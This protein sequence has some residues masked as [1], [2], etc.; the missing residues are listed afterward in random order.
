M[1]LA[2]PWYVYCVTVQGWPGR[3]GPEARKER[4]AM[5]ARQWVACLAA[6]LWAW[7]PALPA[8]AQLAEESEGSATLFVFVPERVS[9][10]FSTD[11]DLRRFFSTAEYDPDENAFV[12]QI[13]VSR[14][15]EARLGFASLTAEQPITLYHKGVPFQ[16]MA[17]IFPYGET[18]QQA[19]ATA[20]MSDLRLS[21]G[22]SAVSLSCPAGANAVRLAIYLPKDMRDFDREELSGSLELFVRPI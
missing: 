22:S 1:A 3:D 12:G 19:N 11:L 14:T 8:S 13:C 7:L 17:R 6:V 21:E 15:T 5:T 18:L 16:G 4:N 2:P 20:G 9:I 10:S